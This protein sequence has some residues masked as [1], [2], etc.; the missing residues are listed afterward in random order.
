MNER[1]LYL[2]M[3]KRTFNSCLSLSMVL[4]VVSSWA[5]V[6]LNATGS[7]N[8]FEI[9]YPAVIQSA[10]NGGVEFTFLAN[11]SIT[12]AATLNLNATGAR[13]ILKNFNMPLEANDIVTGQYVRV[14]YDNSSGG[15]W[16]MLSS[17]AKV[18]S[19]ISGSG[20]NGAVNF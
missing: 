17:S 14:I 11:H 19:N 8:N 18:P 4:C 2:P 15:Q 3:K 16:Q 6:Q 9:I 13:S 1:I 20:T 12:D 5:Q 7:A 10:P